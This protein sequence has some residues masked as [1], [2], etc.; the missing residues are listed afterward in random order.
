MRLSDDTR[1]ENASVEHT[2]IL[3]RLG[4]PGLSGMIR[5]W[6]PSLR[7]GSQV[8][9]LGVLLSLLINVKKLSIMVYTEEG[10]AMRSMQ[11][12]E[13]LFGL[14][15]GGWDDEIHS[16]A[17]PYLP[18]I[19]SMRNVTRLKLAVRIWRYYASALRAWRF[20]KLI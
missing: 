8:A 9:Y 5:H 18:L 10:K 20:W 7:D 3:E 15:L 17:R 13:R 11:P 12:L 6:R 14:S 2:T 4:A 16:A 19:P 1:L